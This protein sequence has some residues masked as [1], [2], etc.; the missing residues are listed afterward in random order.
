MNH[1]AEI[2]LR[3]A[4]PFILQPHPA[5]PAKIDLVETAGDGIEA[6]RIDDDVEREFPVAGP[7]TRRRDPLDR[8]FIDVDQLDIVLI[9]DLII[10]GLERQPP[11][12]R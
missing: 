3:S 7:D 8:R 10:K 9:V 6:G 12:S 2:G 11:R 4:S 1:D 5:K